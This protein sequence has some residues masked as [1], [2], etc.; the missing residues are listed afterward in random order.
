MIN[1]HCGYIPAASK[2][3]SQHRQEKQQREEKRGQKVPSI[4]SPWLGIRTC[5]HTHCLPTFS[6]KHVVKS[7]IWQQRSL[8]D[9]NILCIHMFFHPKSCQ[10]TNQAVD[11][12]SKMAML[13]QRLVKMCT[14]SPQNIW[15]DTWELKCTSHLYLFPYKKNGKMHWEKKKNSAAYSSSV[16]APPTRAMTIKT[17]LF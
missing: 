10:D 11:S 5:V 3:T 4:T 2:E 13:V 15:F 17:I 12:T 8:F 1:K 9:L 16:G 6:I 14:K 7:S